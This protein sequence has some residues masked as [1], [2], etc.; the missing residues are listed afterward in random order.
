MLCGF[1]K[2]TIKNQYTFR[3]EKENGI[4]HLK[5]NWF[6]NFSGHNRA[7]ED[8]LKQRL[9]AHPQSI[10]CTRSEWGPRVCISNKFASASTAGWE[11]Y[12][13]PH[14]NQ[15]PHIHPHSINEEAKAQRLKWV[16]QSRIAGEWRNWAHRLNLPPPPC[17]SCC[18]R[19][20]THSLH[21]RLMCQVLWGRYK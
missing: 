7:L 9:L 18:F 4:S 6:S 10:W 20:V 21:Y 14:N 5:N 2:I 1:L 3:K 12:C 8:L 17:V 15:S 16:V 11:L 19:G 13:E